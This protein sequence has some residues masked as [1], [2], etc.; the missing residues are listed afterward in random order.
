MGKD[1][2]VQFTVS[3][4]G[5]I[6]KPFWSKAMVFAVENF[7]FFEKELVVLRP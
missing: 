2:H 7:T 1:H 5:R 3:P 6:I 4:R